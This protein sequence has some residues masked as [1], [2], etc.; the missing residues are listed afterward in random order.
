MDSDLKKTMGNNNRKE[1]I[2]HQVYYLLFIKFDE[3]HKFRAIQK[4][5]I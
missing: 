4:E 3:Q 1:F 5:Q 2:I